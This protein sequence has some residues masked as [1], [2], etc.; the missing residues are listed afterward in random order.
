MTTE[1]SAS[2]IYSPCARVERG[3]DFSSASSDFNLLGAFFCN[4]ETPEP[5]LASRA[6]VYQIL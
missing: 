5:P 3:A 1:A 2:R 6:P 4:F